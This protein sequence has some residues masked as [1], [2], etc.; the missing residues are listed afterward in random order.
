MT[1]GTAA[2]LSYDFEKVFPH[3]TWVSTWASDASYPEGFRYKVMSAHHVVEKS[4]ELLILRQRRDGSKDVLKHYDVDPSAFD[5]VAATFVEGL[6]EQHGISFEEQ[7]F[8]GC[9]SAEQFENIAAN[10]GWL[11]EPMPSN[12]SLER[13]RDR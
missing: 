3:K 1:D 13:T 5:R 12:K 9:R 2:L 4:V 8:R 11:S 10:F 6:A 7:D